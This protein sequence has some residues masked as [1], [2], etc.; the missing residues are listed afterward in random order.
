MLSILTLIAI[1]A[2]GGC[3]AYLFRDTVLAA[4]F[5]R[6]SPV[7]QVVNTQQKMDQDMIDVPDQQKAIKELDDGQV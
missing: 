7:Q 5:R 6:P 4:I 2:A 1:S 3:I